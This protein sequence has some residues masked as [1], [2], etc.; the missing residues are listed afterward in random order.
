MQDLKRCLI[1]LGDAANGKSPE[2][3]KLLQKLLATD[4][5]ATLSYV[6]THKLILKR[7]SAEWIS[8]LELEL[9][10]WLENAPLKG[11]QKA[12]FARHIAIS[13]A[14]QELFDTVDRQSLSLR[15]WE[16]STRDLLCSLFA[17]VEK[18]WIERISARS[19][20]QPNWEDPLDALKGAELDRLSFRTYCDY[21]VRI[22][23]QISAVGVREDG[24]IS[25]SS[26]DIK[27]AIEIAALG[28][29]V[30]QVLDCYTYKNFRVSVKEKHLT[31]HGHQSQFE[32]ARQWSSL[33]RVSS[34]A[35]DGYPLFQIIKKLEN[36]VERLNLESANFGEFLGTDAGKQLLQESRDVR[37]YYSM[38]LKRDVV[39]EI[40]LDL[41][42]ETRSGTFRVDDLLEC[43]SLV[44][45]LATCATVWFRKF[46][47]E[48][49]AVLKRSQLVSLFTT[50][51]GCVG[52]QAERLVSQ[53]CLVPSESNQDPFFR[54]L[55]RLDAQDLLIATSFVE[56][57]RFSRN[58][59]TISI[60][61]GN[62]DF[63]AKGLKPLK[64]LY[65]KFLDAGF[66][67]LLNFPV[68]LGN[69]QVTDVDIAAAKDGFLFVGQTKVLIRP[70]TQ[71]DDWKVL[72]N[73]RKAASQL[74][75][76]LEHVPT[77]RDRLGLVEGEFLVVPFLLTNIWDFTG[78]TVGGFK[79]VDFNY[80]SMLLTGGEIWS[81][82]FDP[83]P[84]REIGKLIA[85]KYP[86]G[87]ELSRLLQKPIHEAMFERPLLEMSSLRV[88]EWTLDVPL[89]KG[90]VPTR[91]RDAWLAGSQS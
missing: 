38:V 71:Y 90:R 48:T 43:W 40:D 79:V 6:K 87:L 4:F 2:F 47:K 60:R 70:D 29:M 63:S 5:D 11:K 12:Q 69:Q 14:F 9:L 80:L 89:D 81:V 88:G 58:L 30:L 23:S 33:R 56:T 54:P 13:K 31:M 41:S 84:R 44:A 24:A 17:A 19:G 8:E 77:L 28:D 61:E 91:M 32:E 83:V 49:V 72:D 74:R 42:L 82:Q 65:Q 51:L 16:A 55:I 39:N 67:A 85:G 50:S 37:Q 76:S 7:R 21:V 36:I 86:T 3:A 1:R 75:K 64:N 66:M 35:L 57:S 34:E 20:S 52:E 45:Q 15:I 68:K 78:A 26:A 22:V 62:V 59:F 10:H 73:L 25:L 27:G 46:G 53:F 18:F